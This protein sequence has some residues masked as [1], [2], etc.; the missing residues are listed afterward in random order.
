MSDNPYPVIDLFAGAGGFEE[1]FSALPDFKTV[2]SIEN[3]EH[4][5]A[6]LQLRHFFHSF[7]SKKIPRDYQQFLEGRISKGSLFRR[8]PQEAMAA[9][10]SAWR[11]T[12]GSEPAK[13]VTKEI[14]DCIKGK[15]KWVLLGGPPCQTYSIAGRARMSKLPEFKE[16]PRH[17]LYHEFV[18]VIVDHSPPVFVMENVKGL[19]S[20]KVNGKLVIN[21]IVNDL[22][23]PGN[24]EY[25]LFS[26]TKGSL[27]SIKDLVVKSEEYGVPQAR[28]R[29]FIIGVR[30]DVE[31]VPA[32]LKKQEKKSLKEVIKDLPVIRSGLSK[33]GDTYHAWLSIIKECQQHPWYKGDLAVAGDKV[34]KKLIARKD[35]PI[36]RRVP[37]YHYPDSHESKTH[38]M[39]DIQRYFFSIIFSRVNKRSPKLIDFPENLLPR[40]S[41]IQESLKNRAFADRFRVQLSNG[42]SSTITAH[43]SK[44]GHSFIHP[45]PLQCRSFTVR[46]AARIQ[47]FPDNYKFEGPRTSQYRQVGNA[48]PPYLAKQIAEIVRDLLNSY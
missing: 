19:L 36:P 45:D 34:I 40:H 44:D 7:P 12:L 9:N 41:N 27:V 13:N 14:I 33:T 2:L 26:L 31:I 4:P 37:Q 35:D 29:I 15:E 3:D 48:V 32:L 8:F 20:S 23:N 30:N 6:T 16:D 21:E 24:Q 39:D 42:P 17:S 10:K 28:H 25:R 22:R 18:K 38:M 11:C 5:H 47:T 1:G 43:L 46:E